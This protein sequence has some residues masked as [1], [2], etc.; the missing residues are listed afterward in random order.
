MNEVLYSAP[1]IAKAVDACQAFTKNCR[2]IMDDAK[3][4]VQE[5]AAVSKGEY[6]DAFIAAQNK[7]D[8]ALTNIETATNNFAMRLSDASEKMTRTDKLWA[9]NIGSI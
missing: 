6:G 9:N 8:T 4:A 2:T 7:W 3:A 5:R 1:K